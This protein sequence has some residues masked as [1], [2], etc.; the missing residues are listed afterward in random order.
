MRFHSF[1]SDYFQFY[2]RK[3]I[4]EFFLLQEIPVHTVND[5]QKIIRK[6]DDKGKGNGLRLQ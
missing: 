6:I 5:K 2:I 3:K 4:K 1:V